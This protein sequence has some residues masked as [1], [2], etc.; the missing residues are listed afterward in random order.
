MTVFANEDRWENSNVEYDGLRII[1]YDKQNTTSQMRHIDYGL[2]IFKQ[3]AFA[4]VPTLQPYDLAQLYR[5]LLKQNQF[6]AFEVKNRFY[7]IGS[8][9]GLHET[10]QYLA[11]RGK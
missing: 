1:A 4:C 9:V 5:D 11:S 6:A 3:D 2:G 7:E 8:V 10:R